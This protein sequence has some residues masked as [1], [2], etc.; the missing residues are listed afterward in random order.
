MIPNINIIYNN[1][2]IEKFP[3]RNLW[4]LPYTSGVPVVLFFL[5]GKQ[6]EKRIYID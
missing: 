1:M 4:K 6:N 3:D 2:G 5:R